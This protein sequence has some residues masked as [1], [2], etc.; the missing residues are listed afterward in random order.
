MT[1]AVAQAALADDAP[2][3]DP[4]SARPALAGP[5]D[6]ALPQ[7]ARALDPQAMADSFG[8]LLGHLHVAGCEVERV[9]YRPGRNASIVYRLRLCDRRGHRAFEQRV[10]ARLCRPGEALTR[11]RQAQRRQLVASQ[12]GPAVSLFDELDMLVHWWPN[13]AKLGVLQR[14]TDERTMRERVLPGVV[15]ALT[16]GRGRLLTHEVALVQVV[17]ELRVCARVRLRWQSPGSEAPEEATLYAKADLE[18]DGAATQARLAWLAD[19]EA[20]HLGRLHT[21]LPVLWQPE[22]GLHW[23]HAVPGRPLE[24]VEPVPGPV[25][26]ARV[27]R[28]LAALHGTPLPGLRLLTPDALVVQQRHAAALLVAAHPA[29]Q[30]GLAPLLAAL[31]AGA[32][33]LAGEPAV[34]LHGDLHLHN[35]L[36]DGSGLALI[37]LDA[38]HCGPAVLELGA[39][40]ADAAYRG[41]LHGASPDAAWPGVAAFLEAHAAASGGAPAARLLAWS[42]AHH[43]LCRR[44]AGGVANL[45]PGR[46]ARVPG[47]LALAEAVLRAGSIDARPAGA[48]WRMAA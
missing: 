18:Q 36:V 4:P 17:P 39:W 12:A 2:R 8:A 45:K 3:C 41:L 31:E 16:G 19:S 28:Q 30:G 29:W 5:Q 24:E 26:S 23:Q 20:R 38:L 34:T 37:D 6:A 44:A 43:L 13:D 48:A 46:W 22:F 14:L 15:Q 9:K 33:A 1:A 27:A 7:L 47:L 10:A 40:A 21:P 42:M 35:I 32:V 25:T 11:Q